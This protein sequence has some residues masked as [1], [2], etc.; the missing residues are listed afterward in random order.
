MNAAVAD[1]GLAVVEFDDARAWLR[2]RPVLTEP[3]A[4]EV[5]VVDPSYRRVLLVRH[6]R[7]GWVAP[8]GTVEIGETPRAAAV[9]ELAEEAGVSAELSDVPAAVAVRSYRADLSATLCLVYGAVVS[10]EVEVRGEEGQPVGWFS[11]DEEWESVFGEDRGRMRG[12]ARR[13]SVGG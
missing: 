8:G 1:A 6:H 12:F 11:L 4:A 9:R 5:W 2:A 3:I 7:R 10:A 13:L